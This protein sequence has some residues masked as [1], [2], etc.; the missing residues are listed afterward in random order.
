LTASGTAGGLAGLKVDPDCASANTNNA[1][2]V[3]ANKVCPDSLVAAW[4]KHETRRSNISTSLWNATYRYL[5]RA[6]S[7]TI[8]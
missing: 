1:A 4:L 3:Q 2:D 7:L 6:K 5:K 8:P